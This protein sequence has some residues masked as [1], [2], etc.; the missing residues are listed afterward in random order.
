MVFF[1]WAEGITGRLIGVLIDRT[2]DLSLYG[3]VVSS[4]SV[5]T[6]RYDND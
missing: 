6:G 5:V 3:T 4:R 1:P 2:T